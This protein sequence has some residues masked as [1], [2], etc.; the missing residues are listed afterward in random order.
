[1]KNTGLIIRYK[2]SRKNVYGTVQLGDE[3]LASGD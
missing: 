1:V 2:R 3:E